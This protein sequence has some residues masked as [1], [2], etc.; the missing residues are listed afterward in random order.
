M[1]AATL[2]HWPRLPGDLPR[3]PRPQRSALA[4]EEHAEAARLRA[5]LR[6]QA[7]AIPQIRRRVHSSHHL[8][9]YRVLGAGEGDKGPL[10]L[11]LT[12]GAFGQRKAVL[13]GWPCRGA[14]GRS[15]GKRAVARAAEGRHPSDKARE[16]DVR[17]EPLQPVVDY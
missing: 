16:R 10:G 12:C 4:L 17:V 3:L 13:L 9:H 1:A 6:R 14:S 15:G 5:E 2:R 7:E 11:C 8:A